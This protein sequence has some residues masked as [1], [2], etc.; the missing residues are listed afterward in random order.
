MFHHK[1]AN[2]APASS[3]VIFQRST[4]RVDQSIATILGVIFGVIGFIILLCIFTC[5]CGAFRVRSVPLGDDIEEG[6]DRHCTG[7]MRGERRVCRS[8]REKGHSWR[9]V[10]TRKEVREGIVGGRGAG[11]VNRP[12]VEHLGRSYP[13][14]TRSPPPPRSLPHRPQVNTIHLRDV[15]ECLRRTL[16]RAVSPTASNAGAPT[17]MPGITPNAV[18]DLRFPISEGSSSDSEST[19]ASPTMRMPALSPQEPPL[20]RTIVQPIA[21]HPRNAVTRPEFE[22]AIDDLENLVGS[23]LEGINAKLEREINE[24]RRERRRDALESNVIQKE[25]TDELDEETRKRHIETLRT[26]IQQQGMREDIEELRERT[27]NL[28]YENRQT[29]DTLIEI[30]TR[31]RTPPPPVVINNNCTH[32]PNP[33]KRFGDGDDSSSDPSFRGSRRPMGPGPPG[34]PGPP[35]SSSSED[36]F[37]RGHG[38]I[39]LESPPSAPP[40]SPPFRP[41]RGPLGNGGLGM[42]FPEG[43][44]DEG[45]NGF[46]TASSQPSPRGTPRPPPPIRRPSIEYPIPPLN[47]GIPIPLHSR[48]S[49]LRTPL[50]RFPKTP[51]RGPL[52][53]PG[54]L[55]PGGVYFPSDPVARPEA[56]EEPHS[57]KFRD[58]PPVGQFRNVPDHIIGD[59]KPRE[60]IKPPPPSRFTQFSEQDNYRR[61]SRDQSMGRGRVRRG[62]VP[63]SGA[64]DPLAKFDDLRGGSASIPNSRVSFAPS[65]Q[66]DRFSAH[67]QGFD[68]NAG[69]GLPNLGP[70]MPAGL[71][72]LRPGSRRRNGFNDKPKG[73]G[74]RKPIRDDLQSDTASE[75]SYSTDKIR[76][77]ARRTSSTVAEPWVDGEREWYL[78]NMQKVAGGIETISSQDASSDTSMGMDR[79][80][81]KESG[82]DS[83][84][85]VRYKR[86]TDYFQP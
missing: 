25:I 1:F 36:S 56:V 3:Q 47:R 48:P 62:S 20:P 82:V 4:D 77:S 14:L 81:S 51:S 80:G 66:F 50:P 71:Q 26:N 55:G 23:Q 17:S 9:K 41:P 5:C 19:R 24:E 60:D 44:L 59:R 6:S 27:T 40:D 7:G 33:R 12:G 85:R 15:R 43:S 31:P 28:E 54:F 39:R 68:D 53:R 79:E 13:V 74:F 11:G 67:S 52:P 38:P 30:A 35:P 63:H 45:S 16:P 65:D 61:R 70:T 84:G 37:L 86:F 69:G 29:K 21:V 78:R 34:P 58:M 10:E 64:R 8:P 83:D 46:Q 72:H 2:P 42:V 75:N 76:G 49:P 73:P 22:D 32:G 57:P 18:P